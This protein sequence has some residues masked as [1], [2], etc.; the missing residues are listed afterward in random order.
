VTTRGIATTADTIALS[1]RSLLV[2]DRE[3][4]I[5]LALELQESG[6]P[7]LYAI[8]ERDAE[9]CVWFLQIADED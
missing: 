2:Q 7:F 6:Q 1:P 8:G 4:W 3:T 9:P 5:G